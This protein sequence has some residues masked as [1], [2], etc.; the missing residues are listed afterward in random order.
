MLP[1]DFVTT[2][3]CDIYK[4]KNEQGNKWIISGRKTKIAH[5]EISEH[6]ETDLFSKRLS[7]GNSWNAQLACGRSGGVERS[8]RGRGKKSDRE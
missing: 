7:A 3:I 8:H 2:K 4:G 6:D 1:K 5:S